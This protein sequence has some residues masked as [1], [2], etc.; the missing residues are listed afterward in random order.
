MPCS[1]RARSIAVS[2]C[3]AVGTLYAVAAGTGA[4]SLILLTA[5]GA[6][7]PIAG[8]LCVAVTT[9]VRLAAVRFGWAFPEQRAV[10]LRRPK[11]PVKTP[12]E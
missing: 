6:P 9:S 12:A 11:I 4:G 2:T 3:S 10:R 5:L 1:P 7:T 8:L